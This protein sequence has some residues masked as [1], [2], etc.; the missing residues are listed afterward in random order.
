PAGIVHADEF[1]LRQEVVRQS[2][3][4][5]FLS[6]F[7]RVGMAAIGGWRDGYAEGGPV[8]L[9]QPMS[10]SQPMARMVATGAPA[11]QAP[12]IGL[13]MVNVVEPS[14]LANYL[15]DPGSDHV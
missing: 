15:D 6:A 13:R 5:T 1:V 10:V 3:A 4:K 2:G 8:S 9:G 12:R 11:S 14:L 7:N